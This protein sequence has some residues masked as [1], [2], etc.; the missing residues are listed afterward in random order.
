MGLEIQSS[1]VPGTQMRT[2]PAERP[3]LM[4]LCIVALTLIEFVFVALVLNVTLFPGTPEPLSAHHMDPAVETQPLAPLFISEQQVVSM[5]LAGAFFTLSFI[6]FLYQR[7]F[8][9]H[10]TIAKRRFRKWEDEGVQFS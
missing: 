10:V 1:K 6:V 4:G 3:P 8:M 2:T 7:F 9:D 5:W